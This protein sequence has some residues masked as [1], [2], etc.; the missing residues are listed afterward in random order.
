[1]RV[2]RAHLLVHTNAAAHAKF[3]PGGL[4]QCGIGADA[5]GKDHDVA[6]VIRAGFCFH[7]D[8]PAARFEA[9]DAVAERDFDAVLLEVF[10]DRPGHFGIERRH[11]LVEHFD[12]CYRKPAVHE[13]L[14]HFEAD[15]SAPDNHRALRRFFADPRADASAV[16]DRAHHENPR[17]IDAR[18]G[19]THRRSSR[20]ED[21]RVVALAVEPTGRNL[22]HLDLPRRAVDR[23]DL[24]LCA[25]LDIETVSEKRSVC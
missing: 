24:V 14:G 5:D 17:Q 4:C 19:R 16:G 18:Q 2:V 11:H 21:Q 8:P 20:G 3:E 7:R 10:L 15:E 9:R 1:M 22:L 25:D 12:N 13:V 6:S 23:H